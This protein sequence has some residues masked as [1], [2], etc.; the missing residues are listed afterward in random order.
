MGPRGFTDSP[1]IHVSSLVHLPLPGSSVA[2]SGHHYVYD[3][4]GNIASK[5]VGSPASGATMTA[6]GHNTLN[7]ITG[8]GGSAGS[9]MRT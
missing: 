3:S 6:Y 1:T 8:T 7:Q 2:E 5:Q 9:R 4:A